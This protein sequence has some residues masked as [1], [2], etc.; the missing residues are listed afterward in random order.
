VLRQRRLVRRPGAVRADV[1]HVRLTG[2]ARVLG[3]LP[4]Q[5]GGQRAARQVHRRRRHQVHLAHEP[6]EALLPLAS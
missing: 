3:P 5:R 2:Q 1:Q 6:Q 4:P